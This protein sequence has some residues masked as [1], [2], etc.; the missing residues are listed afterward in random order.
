MKDVHNISE[1]FDPLTLCPQFCTAQT[2]GGHLHSPYWADVLY[3]RP[4]RLLARHSSC[5]SSPVVVKNYILRNLAQ[6]LRQRRPRVLTVLSDRLG[7]TLYTTVPHMFSFWPT[8]SKD[9]SPPK[10]RSI[11]DLKFVATALTRLLVACLD[12]QFVHVIRPHNRA[13][14]RKFLVQI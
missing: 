2:Y 7:W 6:I 11:F 13:Y 1:N 10:K 14:Y 5:Q 9:A 3:G 4:L 12:I 8:V